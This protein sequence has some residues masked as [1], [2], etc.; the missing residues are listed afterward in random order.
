MK[1]Q[2]CLNLILVALA[3]VHAVPVISPSEIATKSA[4]GLRLLSLA[5]G[6]EPVWKTEDEK[7]ELMRARIQFVSLV[8]VHRS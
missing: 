5:E 8:G 1:F 6:A 3:S 4:Q 7:L 2:L